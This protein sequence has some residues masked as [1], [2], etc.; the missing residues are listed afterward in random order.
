L[1]DGY[2]I[3]YL[4][5][6]F[7]VTYPLSRFATGKLVKVL[8]RHGVLDQPNH[9]SSHARP[10]PRGGGI[11]VI[12]LL[13]LAWGHFGVLVPHVAPA[14]FTILGLALAL[15]AVSWIDDLRGLNP[16]SRL[17]Y[18]AIAVAIGLWTLP[19]APVFQGLVAPWIDDLMAALLWLWFVN[20]FNFMDGIDGITGAETVAIG[21]GVTVIAA[22]ANLGPD[23]ALYGL[24]LVTITFGFLRWNWQP[25][26]IFL[27]DVGSVPLGYLVGWLLL[28]L[29]AEG[30]WAPAIILPLYYLA[31]AT[32]TLL[33]RLVRG[34]K[35]WLAHRS[36][37]Y[38]RATQNPGTHA[39]AVRRVNAANIALVILAVV[40]AMYPEIAPLL[41]LFAGLIVAVLLWTFA[42]RPIKVPTSLSTPDK[43]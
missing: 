42:N 15:A 36:H 37:F 26:K 17:F 8:H 43:D 23:I 32:I 9:R 12:G 2:L 34:E 1:I 14:L 18:H 28:T 25:A 19:D 31:D 21:L 27:G 6:A 22:L 38:Q 24:T 3:N 7:L 40:A 29:A 5:L 39:G 33:Q 10:V 41:L 35:I 30:H 20:L 11:V 16:F 13:V 4:L